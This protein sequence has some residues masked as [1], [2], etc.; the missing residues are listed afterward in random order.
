MSIFPSIDDLK[1][2]YADVF[3]NEAVTA[4]TNWVDENL[5]ILDVE[6]INQGDSH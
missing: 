5:S 2:M 6:T 4:I 3:A 1:V